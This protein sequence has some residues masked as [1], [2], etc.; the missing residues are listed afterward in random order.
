MKGEDYAEFHT[1]FNAGRPPQ[2]KG[3]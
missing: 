3:R 1:A 2:W